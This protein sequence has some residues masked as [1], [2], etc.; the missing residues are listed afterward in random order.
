MEESIFPEAVVALAISPLVETLSRRL[1]ILVLALVVAAVA[2]Y[3][4]AFA[5]TLSVFKF[6]FVDIA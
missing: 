2:V 5:V 3:A 1:V 4:L 6:S